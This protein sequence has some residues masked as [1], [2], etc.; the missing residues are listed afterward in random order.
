MLT[1]VNTN[2]FSNSLNIK[3][4]YAS[5]NL[6]IKN[7]YVSFNQKYNNENNILSLNNN[8]MNIFQNLYKELYDKMYG[9]INLI[10][11]VFYIFL[12]EMNFKEEKLNNIDFKLSFS[13][14][15]EISDDD[16][17][18]FINNKKLL[19][20][21]ISPIYFNNT[22][23]TII[24]SSNANIYIDKNNKLLYKEF[25]TSSILNMINETFIQY[26]LH[27]MIPS[28]IP[29]VY[30]L[31]K[32]VNLKYNTY[33]FTQKYIQDGTLYD[34]YLLFNKNDLLNILIKICELIQFLQENIDFLH[35]DFKIN[36]ICVDTSNN[37]VYLID[38]GFSSLTYNSIFVCSDFNMNLENFVK[39]NTFKSFAENFIMKHTHVSLNKYKNSSDLL[40]L[41]YTILY[42]Y[43]NDN[44]IIY[45]IL[46][47]LFN[48]KNR[49]NQNIN[50]FDIFIDLENNSF[51]HILFFMSKSDEMFD[52]YF[53]TIINNNVKNEF[54][55]RF[56]PHNL[57]NYLSSFL[58]NNN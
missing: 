27:Q 16:V 22:N 13:N 37:E 21:L 55:N 10:N 34:N 25:D 9:N 50:L 3:N 4:N 39:N 35:N 26:L 38:F 46:Y 44:N 8:N 6:N 41:I 14:Y 30:S 24:T 2:L 42:Y 52:F 15:D 29:K 47:P 32:N 7:N 5:F 57:N 54:F 40:Y 56:L 17:H 33:I 45:D 18:I 43:Q 23:L 48:V 1:L 19:K 51:E 53:N 49:L 28:N 20:E 31:Y 36:N 58:E 12:K 11:H